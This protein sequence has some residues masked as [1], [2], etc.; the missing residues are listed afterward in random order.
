MQML[1]N[2][3]GLYFLYYSEDPKILIPTDI[4]RYIS[5]KEV[6]ILMPRLT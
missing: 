2:V 5:C 3:A 4:I 1:D 6:R